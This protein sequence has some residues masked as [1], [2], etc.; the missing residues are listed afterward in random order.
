MSRTSSVARVG[1]LGDA[2]GCHIYPC[3]SYSVFIPTLVNEVHLH[4]KIGLNYLTRP[5]PRQE[6]NSRT[7]HPAPSLQARFF[8]EFIQES[9][10]RHSMPYIVIVFDSAFCVAFACTWVCAFPFASSFS[11][12]GRNGD[13][14]SS[15][16]EPGCI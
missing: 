15:V 11:V 1:Y 5:L 4:S 7:L 9:G 16:V 12:F 8:V 6:S 13:F 3:P 14:L 10:G 2:A